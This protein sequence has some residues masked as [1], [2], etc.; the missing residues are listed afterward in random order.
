MASTRIKPFPL[1]GLVPFRG[2]L[3]SIT[4]QEVFSQGRLYRIGRCVGDRYDERML[5]DHWELLRNMED[6]ARHAVG[7]T[8]WYQELGAAIVEERA[9]R[10][11]IGAVIYVVR[12]AG[13]GRRMLVHDRDLSA[14]DQQA[15][16]CSSCK[17]A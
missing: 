9:W 4:H 15:A 17:Q 12:G 14:V 1:N 6:L 5:I 2:S 16:V 8:V 11:S 7:D 3:Y 10:F 13:D